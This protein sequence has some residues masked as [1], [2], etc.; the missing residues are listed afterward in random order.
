[1][2]CLVYFGN[3]SMKEDA[4]GHLSGRGELHGGLGLLP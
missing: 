3:I 2:K 1:M 4:S